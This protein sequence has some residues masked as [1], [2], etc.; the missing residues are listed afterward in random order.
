M[1]IFETE[2][3]LLKPTTTEDAAFIFT[4]FN[5]PKWIENIGDRNIKSINDA[6]LYIENNIL[7]QQN[8]LGFSSFTI[9]R[10]EDNLK[11][12]SCGLYDRA[13]LDGIDIGFAFL[14]EYEGKGFAYEAVNE[15]KNKG[16][17]EFGLTSINA[18]TRKENTSSQKL[19]EKLGMTLNGTVKLPNEN[20]ALLLYK[21]EYQTI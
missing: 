5:T 3:L 11:I 1:N 16:F 19:L 9:L 17:S 15:L 12:G 18:I 14:P 6:K 2:R 7:P 21:I 10:K 13:G 8:K 4:L 20:I